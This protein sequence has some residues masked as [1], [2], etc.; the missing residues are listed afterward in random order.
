MAEVVT[1]SSKL[2]S[3]IVAETDDRSEDKT[4]YVFS[5]GRRFEAGAGAYAEPEA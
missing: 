4:A 1:A 2:W 5:N 3:E